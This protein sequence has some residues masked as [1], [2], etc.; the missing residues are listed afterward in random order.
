MK[1][2]WI[3]LGLAILIG[4]VYFLSRSSYGVMSSKNVSVTPTPVLEETVAPGNISVSIANFAFNPA[5]ITIPALTE[6]TF[7]NN[8]STVHTVTADDGSFDSGQIAPRKIFRHAF[9]TPGTF[10][11]HCLIHTTMKGGVV[12]E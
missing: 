3:I 7:T 2:F 4:I 11:Y 1:Y 12:V 6:V 10:G 8:D 5:T 9:E